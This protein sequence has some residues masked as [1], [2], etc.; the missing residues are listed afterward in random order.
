MENPVLFYREEL[1]EMR[2]HVSPA[3]RALK[4]KYDKLLLE[5]QGLEVNVDGLINQN[6]L[7]SEKLVE[8]SN[9]NNKSEGIRS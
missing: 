8:L 4:K 6:R 5:K 1:K 7:L 9:G 2:K 3:Y